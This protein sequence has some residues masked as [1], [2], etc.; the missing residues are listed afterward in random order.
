MDE[1]SEEPPSP[2]KSP[3]FSHHVAI[4][5]DQHFLLLFIMGTFFG[6]D[7]KEEKPHKSVLQRLAEDLPPYTSDQLAGSQLK[8]V[9]A[10]RIYHYV[11]R[12]ADRSVEVKQSVLHQFF[13]GTLF[14]PSEDY[15]VEPRQFP[16]LFPLYLHPQ[17]KYR[18]RYKI[19]ENVVFIDNPEIYYVKP[20]DIKRF[21]KLT[22][23]NDLMLDRDGARSYGAVTP[24]KP[25]DSGG[26][27]KF[28]DDMLLKTCFQSSQKKR[29]EKDNQRS[30]SS[31]PPLR[32]MSLRGLLNNGMA[33]E[34]KPKKMK[35]KSERKVGPVS[36]YF[37][38]R[39]TEKEW[40]DIVNASK[41]A[42]SLTGTVAERELGSLI[43]LVDIGVCDDAYLFHISLPGVKKDDGNFTCGVESN[44]RVLIKG[45][46]TTGDSV[47]Y[48][49][50]V[51][52]MKT[53]NL[54]SSG[55]F[56]ISFQLPGPVEPKAFYGNL[57]SD[58][59]LEG[60]VLRERSSI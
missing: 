54:C 3:I 13:L 56:T 49:K 31:S 10:E 47:V 16:D 7:L 60:I 25:V 57:G 38:D 46:T 26:A 11:L 21:K 36:L 59:I 43:G 42:V 18:N 28:D 39:P 27:K 17:S 6:P 55:P 5:D 40:N 51:F 45:F 8:S 12:K 35:A 1:T 2:R 53:Q 24:H 37:P 20:E 32:S 41:T 4:T 14:S 50:Q 29:K 23:L 15:A 44:G 34:L 22:R 30:R 48:K 9:E 33:E 58:G 52:R 19:F